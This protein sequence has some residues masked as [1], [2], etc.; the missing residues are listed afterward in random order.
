[1]PF[2]I[3]SK[4]VTQV[5]LVFHLNCTK[6]YTETMLIFHPS[7]SGRKKY[8]E[9]TSVFFSSKLHQRKYVKMTWKFIDIFIQSIGLIS[10]SN[11][12][13]FD[14]VY[15]LRSH[16][17][18]RLTKMTYKSEFHWLKVWVERNESVKLVISTQTN[19]IT[20]S[21]THQSKSNWPAMWVE[22]N[23]THKLVT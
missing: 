21:L 15:P 20:S 16:L 11:R 1:M 9:L 7:K 17:D 10:A 5:A 14:V 3:T 4:Y 6:K 18:W 8:I 13:S 22:Q 23:D 19:L 12:R 2:K